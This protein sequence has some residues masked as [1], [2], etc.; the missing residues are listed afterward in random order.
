MCCE[1]WNWRC[2]G[3]SFWESK[4]LLPAIKQTELI[5]NWRDF[6]LINKSQKNLYHLHLNI[7]KDLETKAEFIKMWF[8]VNGHGY[9]RDDAK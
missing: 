2:V 4:A 3:N 9:Y 1:E 7:I 6:Q 5:N 8:Q